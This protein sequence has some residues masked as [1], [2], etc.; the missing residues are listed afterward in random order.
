MI[1]EPI[2]EVKRLVAIPV[3][4]EVDQERTAPSQRRLDRGRQ[5][6][7][8]RGTLPA[9]Q[10]EQRR[11]VAWDLDVAEEG[12]ISREVDRLHADPPRGVLMLPARFMRRL[13]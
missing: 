1:L 7:A 12:P 2:G 11:I 4:E 3:A 9:M 13:P 5:Q 10:P 8:G 6:L